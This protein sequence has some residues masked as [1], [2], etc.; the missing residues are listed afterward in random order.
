MLGKAAHLAAD[1]VFVDLEDAVAPSEKSDETR[2]SVVQALLEPEWAAPTRGVRVNGVATPWC[3]R[4]MVRIVEGAGP[5]LDCIVLPKVKSASHVHFADHLLSQLETELGLERRIGLE[6]QIESADGLVAIREIAAA[7]DRTETLVFGPGDFAASV[8]MPQLTIGASDPA[9]RGDL[10][11]YALMR[12]VTTARAHGLQAIDGPYAAIRDPE[13]L[14]RA[15]R[16]SRSLGFDGKWV[17]HPD[18]I[19]ICNEVYR[20]SPEEY[21]RA[22]R[23]LQ[24]YAIAS[25]V[26]GAGA[27]DLKGEMVDEATRK[28]AEQVA[29]RGRAAG[30]TRS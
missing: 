12:I 16:S 6:L 29:A 19:A 26:H 10:W 13:G 4:D 27:V 11:H 9:Y 22:E 15:A 17:L 18:Q 5:V 1:L 20:P 7:S 2:D 23:L 30:M 8:G 14:R 28:M 24:A 25:G 3:H 21:E